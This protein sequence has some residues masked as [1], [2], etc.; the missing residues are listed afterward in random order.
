MVLELAKMNKIIAYDNFNMQTAKEWSP[1]TILFVLMLYTSTQATANLP[2]HIVV[3]FK[4]VTNIAIVFGEW[5]LFNEPGSRIVVASLCIMLFGAVM[6]SKSDVES[7]GSDTSILGY[8]WM[9]MNCA[10]T[11]GYILYMRFVTSRP[12]RKLSKFGMAFYNNLIA[13]VLLVPVM[14]VSGDLFTVWTSP[15]FRSLSFV[16]LLIFSGVTGVGLN[17]SSFWC[18]SVTSATTY[19][20]VGALNKLP[21][22]FVGVLILGEPLTP[23]TAMY[24]VFGMIGG[25]LYGYAKFKERQ[26]ANDRRAKEAKQQEDEQLISEKV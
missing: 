16:A 10:C 14:A 22:T 9:L 5:K 11:A 13:T 26:E 20:T 8:F 4:N 7:G 24:V 18:V 21:T 17:L 23:S 1:V 2:I 3:V 19:A 15:L 12:N 6:A 25:I